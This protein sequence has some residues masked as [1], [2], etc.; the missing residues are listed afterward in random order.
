MSTKKTQLQRANAQ[1]TRSS[2][3]LVMVP[4]RRSPDPAQPHSDDQTKAPQNA[5]HRPVAEQTI[6]TTSKI[7]DGV[8][9]QPPENAQTVENGGSAGAASEVVVTMS[10]SGEPTSGNPVPLAAGTSELSSTNYG[11]QN[12]ITAPGE[13]ATVPAGAAMA[14]AG[15]IRPIALDQIR[16]DERVQ[17]RAKVVPKVVD[18]YTDAMR[19]G[20]EFP[21]LVVFQEGGTNT[22]A[23]GFTR[24]AAAKLA[25]R[26]SINCEVR[27]G[28]LRD[29][30]LFAAGANATHGCPR[31][32]ADKH[33]AVLKLLN[34]DEWCK[35]SDREIARRCHVGH[36]LVAELREVTGRATSERKFRSKHGS[37]GKMNVEKIGK[38]PKHKSS[39]AA[40]SGPEETQRSA[41]ST[42][43]ANET[44]T[45]PDA[46]AI[47]ETVAVP[48]IDKPDV[49]DGG[50]VYAKQD[51]GTDEALAILAEF[52]KFVIARISYQAKNIIV[53]VTDEDADQFRSL[54]GRA[55][56]A[57]GTES[58]A[59]GAHSRSDIS[60]QGKATEGE[61]DVRRRTMPSGQ[62]RTGQDRTGQDRTGQDRTG[63]DRK[64]KNMQNVLDNMIELY[65]Q[66]ICYEYQRGL[67]HQM[68][69]DFSAERRTVKDQMTSVQFEAGI[70]P[71]QAVAALRGII[72][73]IEE[74]GLP[75][76]VYKMTVWH[77]MDLLRG[78]LLHPKPIPAGQV[79]RKR[80]I[81]RLKAKTP[82][83]RDRSTRPNA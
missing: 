6:P 33:C 82:P 43:D 39:S 67:S 9:P 3:R 60:M 79:R 54:C 46:P 62:D 68:M 65:A 31:S 25:G 53:T 32:T 81:E 21:P 18:D 15:P 42:A 11:T 51:V 73:D 23:D 24:Y 5:P 63:Q 34:D 48:K 45:T 37:A 16:T 58:G 64:G 26:T 30:I 77:A 72:K 7:L 71:K 1:L 44:E 78:G 74:D 13:N 12:G 28:G 59:A 70:S 83:N 50:H 36:Q 55:E 17:A 80:Q 57:I 47:A 52:A 76:V 49:G 22:L 4:R 61:A 8:V 27:A 2:G 41:Q 66:T 38:K 56:L 14:T 40:S 35:W 20:D 19:E 75:N 10:G 69:S 29:A